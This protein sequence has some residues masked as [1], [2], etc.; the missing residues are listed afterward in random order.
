MLY[1]FDE[2]GRQLTE[3]PLGC[4]DVLYLY[5]N[6]ILQILFDES[7]RQLTA[8]PSADAMIIAARCLVLMFAGATAHVSMMY[9]DGQPGAIRNA[10]SP[11]GARP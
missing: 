8:V 9:I 11:T 6:R 3:Y 10:N 5:M 2:S 1:L 4:G 7:G